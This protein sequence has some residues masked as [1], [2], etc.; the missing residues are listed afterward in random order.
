[1]SLVH[2]L[3]SVVGNI[4]A[5]FAKFF[6]ENLA[7]QTL[8]LFG[9]AS[10]AGSR[11]TQRRQTSR[12]DLRFDD[13]WHL[14]RWEEIILLLDLF[15]QRFGPLLWQILALLYNFLSRTILRLIIL[16]RARILIISMGRIEE[17]F[18][19]ETLLFVIALMH[20]WTLSYLT[21][22]QHRNWKTK[23][24]LPTGL[25]F[26]WRTSPKNDSSAFEGFSAATRLH[27]ACLQ[28]MDDGK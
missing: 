3:R 8:Q 11:S 23:S 19:G 28:R 14:G 24:N 27:L 20:S 4:D 21:W 6:T 15:S 10:F 26:C 16:E 2:A 7:Q 12:V 1:M 22:S 25:C 9:L 13:T 17:S 18:V 5:F